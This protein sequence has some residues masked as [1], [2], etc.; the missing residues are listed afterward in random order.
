MKHFLNDIEITPRNRMEIGLTQNFDGNPLILSLTTDSI[1]LPR[2]ANS[3]I[4]N[5]LATTGIFEGIPYRVELAAGINI[6]YYIDFCD[7]FTIRNHEVEVKIKKRKGFDDFKEKADGTSFEL[8]SSQGVVFDNFDVP[9]L[10]VDKDL[11]EKAIPLIVCSYIMTKEVIEAGKQVADAIIEAI[12]AATPSVGLG[13]VMDTGDIIALALKIIGR[14]IIFALLLSALLEMATQLFEMCFP[15]KRKLKGVKFFE[16]AKKGCEYLGY[17]FKSTIF[18]NEP[19]WTLL[20]VPLSKG[21]KSIFDI[22][23]ASWTWSFNKGYPSASDTTP[24]LGMFLDGI[25][26]MFNARIKVV[27]NIVYFERWDYWSTLVSSQLYPALNLQSNRD[28]EYSFNTDDVWKRYYIKYSTDSADLHTLDDK[29]YDNHDAELSTEILNAT[30]IDLVSIKGLQQV[31]IPFA[32]GARKAKLNWFEEIAK[33]IFKQV[34]NVANFFGGSTNYATQIGDRKDCLMISQMYFTTT[35]ALYTVSGKQQANYFDIVSAKSLWERY[36]NI[37]S[38]TL[39]GWKIINNARIKLT[40]SEFVSLFENNFVYIDG[41]ISEILK[42]TYIDEK[43]NAE[44]SYRIKNNYAVN[45][46]D[47]IYINT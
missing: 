1:I 43:A 39:N 24:T 3:I 35:K 5:H 30:N 14:I 42:V 45:K 11:L 33:G 18:L 8:M 9:Y 22:K 27:N 31:D 32:L 2:E 12:Q 25:E 34:D 41:E 37:N 13:V 40:S 4:M 6:E 44:I 38:I 15:I 46:V 19:N 29:V 16:L 21:R 28:F 36:H 10:I 17:T 20:P 7:G 47:I 26:T 23:P